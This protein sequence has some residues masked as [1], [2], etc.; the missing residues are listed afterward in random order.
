V[1]SKESMAS[2][3]KGKKHQ[4]ITKPFVFASRRFHLSLSNMGIEIN[5]VL[6]KSQW[7]HYNM[8]EVTS[9]ENVLYIIL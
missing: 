8:S 5:P 4:C 9:C 6:E 2:A 1:I 3:L 7:R